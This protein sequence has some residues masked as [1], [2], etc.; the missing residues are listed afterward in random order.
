MLDPDCFMLIKISVLHLIQMTPSLEEDG[1]GNPISMERQEI[2]QMVKSRM[3]SLNL[4][5][6]DYSKSTSS[7]YCFGQH[8]I[9]LWLIK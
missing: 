3:Q 8:V 2:I 1:S 5:A 9:E 7:D 6:E 4:P